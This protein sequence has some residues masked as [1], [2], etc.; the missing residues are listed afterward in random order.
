MGVLPLR[1]LLSAS[2]DQL[3]SEIMVKN[4]VTISEK[5]TLLDAHKAFCKYKFLSLPVID[6]ERRFKGVLDVTAITGESLNLKQKQR[7]DD[8]FETIGIRSSFLSYLT[9]FSSFKHRFPWLI[10]TIISGTLCAVIAA[11]FEETIAGSLIITF[12]LTLVLGLGESVSMQSLT[13]TIRRLHVENSSWDWFKGALF[14]ELLTA[15]FL[16]TGT[17]A[18]VGLIIFFWKSSLISGIVVGLS[19]LLSLL[20]ACFF[21]FTIPTLIHRMKLDPKIAAG[22][23]ALAFSDVFTLLFYFTLA[24]LMS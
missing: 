12:F 16:G 18:L 24:K 1:R 14:A 8:V 3:L 10:P 5:E 11:F 20:T 6:K 22:P 9:P 23:L 21:G 19:I 17:G 13:I 2:L 15:V 4:V 7:F